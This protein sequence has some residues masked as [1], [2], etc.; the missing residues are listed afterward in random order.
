MG[1]VCFPA[2]VE[3]GSTFFRVEKLGER[4]DPLRDAHTAAADKRVKRFR[5]AD[6]L[7]SFFKATMQGMLRDAANR[8]VWRR[9][10][11]PQQF[12]RA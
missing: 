1:R 11:K 7:G 6:S 9:P 2:H 10:W 3:Q 12:R 8:E 5:H 4:R